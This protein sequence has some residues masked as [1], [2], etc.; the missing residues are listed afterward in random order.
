MNKQKILNLLGLATRARLITIG[1]DFVI[2]EMAKG[3]AL[4]FLASDSGNNIRKKIMDKAQTYD[5]PV[6]TELNSDE[7]S[8]A[9]GKENRRVLLINDKGFIKKF[10]EY[11]NS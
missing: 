7:L 8:S 4:V 1:V 5:I 9:I 6:Y 2:K 3:N 10:T 11:I